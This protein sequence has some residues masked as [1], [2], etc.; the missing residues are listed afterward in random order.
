[1]RAALL[2]GILYCAIVFAVGF[3]LGTLRVTALAPRFGELAAVAIE[4]PAML[5]ASWLAS[6]WLVR[7]FRVPRTS[8]ARLA[9]GGLALV[10]LLAAEW[11]LGV[12][13]F[14]RGAGEQLAAWTSPPG[15]L[16]LAAQLAFGLVPFAQAQWVLRR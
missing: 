10:L 7:T 4:V 11:T 15:L 9:M 13:L 1:M 6:G 8:V 14:G 2:A 5:L 12:V 3:A 16:G